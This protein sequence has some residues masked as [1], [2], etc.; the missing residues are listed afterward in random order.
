MN[1]NLILLFITLI[2]TTLF[3][4]EESV[5]DT[6]NTGEINVVKPY[7]PTISD[8]FKIKE[9]PTLDYTDIPKD[10]VSYTINSVPVASTFTP[11]KGKAKG[12]AKEKL[13][14]IYANYVSVGFGNNTTPFLEAYIHSSS[15]RNNDYGVF[16]NHLSSKGNVKDV[17][18][19][20]NFSDTKVNL[21]YKQFDRDYNWEINAGLKHQ[22]NNWYGL[23]K[24]ITYSEPYLNSIDPKQKY[25]NVFAGGKL[26]FED[27]IFKGG[28]VELNQF[29]DNYNSNEIHLLVQ[30]KVEFPISSELINTTAT[31]EFL[32]GKF[33]Q[34]YTT[35]NNI[36][37][38][39]LKLGIAPNFKVLRDDLTVNLG[40]RI[41]Y[42]FDLENSVNKFFAYPNVTASYKISEETLIAYAGI[43]GDLH[44]NS[45]R[46]FAQDN[47]FV[48]PTLNVSQTD[49]QYNAYIG[50]KGQ[51][52]ADVSYNFKASFINE[53]G[54]PLYIQNPSKTDG[55]ITTTNSYELGNSFKVIY[56]N[57]KTL[58]VSGEL[59]I[60]FS[61]DFKF[62]GTVEFDNYTTK[63]EDEAWNLP[64]IKAALFADYHNNKWF[65][66]SNLYFVGKR[67][68]FVTPFVGLGEK[69]ELDSFIDL[70]L[71]GGYVFTDRLTAFAKANNVLSTNNQRYANFDTQGIQVLLGITYKFDF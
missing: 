51:L 27:G 62:G 17:L 67:Y 30:P 63:T 61:K 70:N 53:R 45:F 49:K 7:T 22:I 64:T 16:I 5:R 19:D 56:D 26:H 58:A 50:A 57:V 42:S 66:G 24:D 71:K 35:I 60:D 69:V 29:S 38:N 68:D 4:Q 32:S 47:P 8:A 39:F 41:Y 54:K 48:S 37:H 12:V 59:N 2:S 13:D 40:A 43:T 46:E 23:P 52:N 15:T 20:N 55:V 11:V 21:Y 1:K 25:F 6:L 65:A 14:K 10:S 36:N 3:A 44:L 33:N 31:I 34:N 18:L 28:K 9:N